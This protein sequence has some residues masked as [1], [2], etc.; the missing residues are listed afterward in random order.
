MPSYTINVR[1]PNTDFVRVK[2]LSPYRMF[3]Q[4]ESSPSLEEFSEKTSENNAY[5]SIVVDAET[6]RPLA[7]SPVK[8]IPVEVFAQT[9]VTSSPEDICITEMVEGTMINL[10]YNPHR[11]EPNWEIATKGSVGGN[12]CYYRTIYSDEP[13]Y[14]KSKTFRAMFYDALGVTDMETPLS[15]IPKIA[16]LPKQYS[17]CFVL[18]HP[19]NHMVFDV[20]RPRLILVSMFDLS[21]QE[22]KGLEDGIHTVQ[23]IHPDNYRSITKN[24]FYCARRYDVLNMNVSSILH[25]LQYDFQPGNPYRKQLHMGYCVTNMVTGERTVIENPAYQKLHDLRGNHPNMEYQYL[26]LLQTKRLHMFLLAFPRYTELFNQF[27]TKTEQFIGHIHQAYISYYVKRS[28]AN[29]EKKWFIHAARIHH[30]IFVPSLTGPQGKRLI[31]HQI[32]REYFRALSVKEQYY[33]L[34]YVIKVQGP[35]KVQEPIKEE[36][37]TS[38]ERDTYADALLELQQ[39]NDMDDVPDLISVES[40]EVE[41]DEYPIEEESSNYA[42]A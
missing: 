11:I 30:Q 20:T 37:T 10:F 2:D 39:E 27:Y 23:L 19:E 40:G 16:N 42:N 38:L 24:A 35:N 32:V 12:F 26:E 3:L 1:T 5:R 9:C 25:K 15:E 28:T 31:T 17:Y 7:F 22:S 36:P 34:N 33:S 6:G 14:T 18:Q 13:E 41:E 29:I 8:S 4:N 21:G